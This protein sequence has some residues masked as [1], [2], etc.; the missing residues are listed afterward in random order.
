G[1]V[2]VFK[3]LGI[4][5]TGRADI[6]EHQ[7]FVVLKRVQALMNRTNRINSIIIR[8]PNAYDA[9]KVAA[10]IENQIGYKS[11]SW[12]EAWEDLL[13]T[14]IVRNV[15]MYA[16]VSAVL[17]VAAF[18]IYNVISTVVL[19]KQRDIAILKSMGFH[20]GDIRWIFVIQGTVLGILGCMAGL[21]LGG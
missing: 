18:G 17:V 5:R 16:V 10:E 2:R 14:L 7:V 8:L 20:A 1:Q 19:E 21:P 9:R 13:S 15:I 3:I 6:D 11:V 4:F 12:Q